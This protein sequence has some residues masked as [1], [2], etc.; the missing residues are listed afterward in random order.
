[1]FPI[2]K[3]IVS[4]EGYVDLAFTQAMDKIHVHV[5]E[6]A[7]PGTTPINNLFLNEN[8]ELPPFRHARWENYAML[9]EDAIR[10][11][12]FDAIEQELYDRHVLELSGAEQELTE[13]IGKLQGRKREL[14]AESDRLKELHFHKLWNAAITRIQDVL[15]KLNQPV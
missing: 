4:E 7:M 1:M 5:V 8:Y 14:L 10:K 9:V 3:H 6:A 15:T 11:V 12:D 2:T 13:Q